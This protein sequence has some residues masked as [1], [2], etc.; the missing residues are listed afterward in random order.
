MMERKARS[1]QV[2][3]DSSNKER[4]GN[5]FS[6]EGTE[7]HPHIDFSLG[8]PWA[9]N[10]VKPCRLIESVRK[11]CCLS[12]QVCGSLLGTYGS[13]CWGGHVERSHGDE[14]A[15]QGAQLFQPSVVWVL[16]ASLAGMGFDFK[17]NFAP[18]TVLPRLFLCPWM[19]GIFF[20]WDPAFSCQWLF[21][22]GFDPW[23]EKIPWRKARQPIPVFLPGESHK[24]RSLAGYSL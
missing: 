22:H 21:S 15:P 1:Q 19:W 4:P 5:R 13:S 6:P 11:T 14:E 12:H 17:H 23:V 10:Q 2:Q 24:Q 20:W 9:E 16:Q 8:R 3:A 18:P 7:H